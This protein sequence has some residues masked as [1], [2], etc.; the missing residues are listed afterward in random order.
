MEVAMDVR[1]LVAYAS[2]Y[3]G[4]AEIAKR[5]GQ[6]ISDAGLSIDVLEVEKVKGL[7]HY[8]AVVLG[9]ALY[10]GRW[11]REAARFLKINEEVL[12]GQM[13]WLFSSGPTDKGDPLELVEGL[14]LPKGLQP[15]ADRIGPEDIVIFHGVAALEKMNFFERWIMKKIKAPVGDFRDW[16]MIVSWAK[17]IAEGLKRSQ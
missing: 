15:V 17:G 8:K 3:G 1:V 5:I 10:M 12:E 13:V 2:K 7:G 9:S 11:R 16:E 4:T 14:Y 6:V